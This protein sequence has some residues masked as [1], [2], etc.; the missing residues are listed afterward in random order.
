MQ[1]LSPLGEEL[2]SIGIPILPGLG[3]K[4]LQKE[5]DLFIQQLRMLLQHLPRFR[6]APGLQQGR[7]GPQ[8]APLDSYSNHLL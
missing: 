1:K 8:I 7:I 6:L 3:G 4:L 5:I 2:R